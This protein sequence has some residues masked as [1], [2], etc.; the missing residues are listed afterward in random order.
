M[1][2][3]PGKGAQSDLAASR[4][5]TLPL[6]LYH[7]FSLHLASKYPLPCITTSP[8]PYAPYSHFD[9]LYSPTPFPPTITR[10]FLTRLVPHLLSQKTPHPLSVP[11]FLPALTIASY[12]PLPNSHYSYCP[13][14]LP[15]ASHLSPVIPPS[16]PLITPSTYSSYCSLYLSAPR[17]E[18]AESS[19]T[20]M[21]ARNS[22]SRPPRHRHGPQCAGR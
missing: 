10:L 1:A 20:R 4:A 18:N 22:A 16:H 3:N 15:Q 12:P 11:P 14:L 8:P 7:H 21:A 9:T 2:R 17:P 5:R 19:A 13:I 6:S